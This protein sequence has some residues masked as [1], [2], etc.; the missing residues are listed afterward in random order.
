MAPSSTFDWVN[1]Y[2]I[3]GEFGIVVRIGNKVKIWK[4]KKMDINGSTP[5]TDMSETTQANNKYKKALK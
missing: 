5:L 3:I 2:T 4:I 1:K